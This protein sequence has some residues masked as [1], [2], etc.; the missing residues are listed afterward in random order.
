MESFYKQP[1]QRMKGTGMRWNINN[2]PVMA[3]QWRA[4]LPAAEPAK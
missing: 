3:E 4:K 2:V 1:G